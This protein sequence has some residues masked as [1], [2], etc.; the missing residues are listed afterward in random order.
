MVC[1]DMSTLYS[2]PDAGYHRQGMQDR[3][4]TLESYSMQFIRDQRPVG[5]SRKT[6]VTGNIV[7]I[8]CINAFTPS[9]SVW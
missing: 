9:V 2:F 7:L 5:E 8:F 3:P 1:V 4:H 6:V